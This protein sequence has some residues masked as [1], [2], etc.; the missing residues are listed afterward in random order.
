[1]KKI[2]TLLSVLLFAGSVNV[3]AQDTLL[4]E[5]FQFVMDSY[6]ISVTSPPVGTNTDSMWYNYDADQLA[7]GAGGTNARPDDWWQILAFADSNLYIQGTTDT[8][9]VMGANSWFS[10]PGQADNW[11]ITSNVQLGDHD[12]LFWKAAPRQ[13]PRYV[14]GYEVRLSTTTNSDLAFT[15]LL[16]TAAEMTAISGTSADS[17]FSGYTFS[18]P[19]FVHGLDG[20]Y[21]EFDNDSARLIGI[22]KPF[23]MPLDAY[24]NQNVFIAFHHTSFDDNLISIDDI[25]IRGTASNPI[26]GIKENKF[27]LNLNVFP[28]PAGDNAQL[29]FQLT[30]ETEVTINV[31]DVTG[32]LVY[33]ENKGS[34]AHGRHF[35]TINTAALANGFYTIAV[36]TK[37][38]TSTTKLIVQ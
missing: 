33:S 38:G 7:D 24:A 28:N 16:F 26:A 34:L 15:N 30:A 1:M 35:A 5:G 4:Y 14:D 12:T 19:G 9:I 31:N 13:T 36:Q 25:M 17:T 29:N 3:K 6:L 27:D 32:K 8:N 37:N 11:L 22:L 20:T 2:Y 23:S 18:T 21:T 10:S